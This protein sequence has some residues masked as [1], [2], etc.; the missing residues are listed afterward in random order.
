MNDA[1]T[2]PGRAD[3][4]QTK[5]PS[6]DRGATGAPGPAAV[7]GAIGAPKANTSP[8]ADYDAYY[9]KQKEV[10]EAQILMDVGYLRG[11][12]DWTG[13]EKALAAYLKH[14]GK[15]ASPWMYEQLGMAKE[16]LNKE[17][18]GPKRTPESIRLC[19]GQAADLARRSKDPIALIAACDSLLLR[20]YHQIDLPAPSAPVRLTELLDQAIAAA[21]QKPQPI[22]MSLVLAESQ[23]DPKRAYDAAEKLMSLGWPG[24]DGAWRVEVPKRLNALVKALREDGREA[25]AM[26]LE[27]RIPGLEA[28]DVVI[29][30]T[31]GGDAMLELFVDEPL[32]ATA[33]HF[34]PRTVFGGAL[35]K[36]GTPKDH[37]IVYVCPRG[38]DGEYVARVG[39][40]Y[41]D[42]KKPAQVAVVELITHE[43]TGQEKVQIRKVSISKPAASRVTLEGGRR[44]EVL[45][46]EVPLQINTP[47]A[48]AAKPKAD[49]NP[50]AP[51]P[52]ASTPAPKTPA[53]AP[54]RPR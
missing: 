2:P 18:K 52:K 31:W 6:R 51:A 29:R 22:L 23:K 44:K 5:S 21:P 4:S 1:L 38:F 24:V 30:V 19:F 26:S 46:Y 45:P 15:H 43:G 33:S 25:D 47:K 35:V 54:A 34:S 12:K 3:T 16:I 17:G 28:R 37:E 32:G 14:H 41:N 11:I 27:E 49:A 7:S 39:V 10:S 9:G 53:P 48:D 20:K 50:S 8:V 42:P 36:E 40:L 13:I